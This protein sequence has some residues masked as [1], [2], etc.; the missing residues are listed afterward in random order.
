MHKITGV[1]NIFKKKYY[2][3][4]K[5]SFAKI[6]LTFIEITQLKLQ[7]LHELTNFDDMAVFF[8]QQG[9]MIPPKKIMWPRSPTSND[10][11][12]RI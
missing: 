6:M 2:W 10:C 5:V 3:I 9:S 12:N 1:L 4:F 7:D 11:V 8:S